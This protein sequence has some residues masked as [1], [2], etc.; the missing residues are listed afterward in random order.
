MKQNLWN[1]GTV[2]NLDIVITEL[3]SVYDCIE[4]MCN[5][6]E[7]EKKQ[8][9]KQLALLTKFPSSSGVSGSFSGKKKSKKV[10]SK[11]KLRHA[12]MSCHT[13]G[14]EGYWIPEY[15]KKKEN[16]AEQAKFGKSTHVVIE[17]SR[18]WKVRKMLIAIC[19]GYEIRQVNMAFIIN[20]VNSVLLDCAV[21][22][23]MFLE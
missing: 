5:I 21:T 18:N 9:A 23:H 3:L 11:S 6:E 2:L 1:K 20:T 12:D 8:K 17:L 22:S 14:E 7:T 4:S 16:K 10:R 15:P 19:N 13:C